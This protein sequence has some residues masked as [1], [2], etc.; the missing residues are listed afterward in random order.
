MQKWYYVIEET[1]RGRVVR[2]AQSRLRG[3]LQYSDGHRARFIVG[4]MDAET[5]HR[6]FPDTGPVAEKEG[7]I[8]LGWFGDLCRHENAR[9]TLDSEVCESC[10]E[11]RAARREEQ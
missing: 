3:A 10:G 1:S 2:A 6:I 11:E 7:L 5:L 9:E 4:P 8:E